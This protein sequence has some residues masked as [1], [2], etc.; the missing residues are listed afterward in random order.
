MKT[1]ERIKELMAELEIN[2]SQLA[3]RSNIAFGTINRILNEKQPLQPNTL[4]KIANALNVPTFELSDEADSYSCLSN[5]VNGY[6]EFGGEIKRIRSFS[7]LELWVKK[8]KPLVNQ[9]PQ[10]AKKII[11]TNEKRNKTLKSEF[12]HKYDFNI[13]DLN[14]VESYDTTKHNCW[15]FKNSDDIREG[16]EIPLGNQCSGFPFTLHGYQFLTSESAYLC[17]QFSHNTAEHIAI[18]KELLEETNGYMAKKKIKKQN[19]NQ[20]RNDWN[21][22]NVQWI[23]FTLWNKCITN[24]D[25][26]GILLSIPSDAIIIENSTIIWGKTAE[27]WGSMNKELEDARNTIEKYIEFQNPYMK[28]KELDSL[29]TEERNKVNCIGVFTNGRNCMGKILKLCQIALM[30]GNEPPINY[31]LLNEKKIHL[32]GKLLRL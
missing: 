23:L 13:I 11:R 29:I 18:Q 16:I 7:E 1:I 31:A 4:Q 24:E 25:F 22:F 12:I 2:Q 3:E 26:K 15:S 28:R 27:V 5:Q 17:G 9:L 30:E 19:I 32:F 14:R 6:L 8:I 10:Q 21:D 20:I